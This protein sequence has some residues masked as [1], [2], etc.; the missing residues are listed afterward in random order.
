VRV[1]RQYASG[2]PGARAGAPRREDE[3]PVKFVITALQLLLPLIYLGAGAV[4]LRYYVT[5]ARPLRRL[6][7]LA[8]LT[9]L[10]THFVFLLAQGAA[11]GWIPLISP[12][13]AMSMTAAAILGVYLVIEWRS[14]N[15][16]MGVFL[17]APALLF[18]VLSTFLT[19]E[20]TEVPKI[21]LSVRLP[22]HALPAVL[23]YA[24]LAIG[25]VFSMLMLVLR[26]QIKR[27]RIGRI[28]RRLPSLRVLDT[29]SFHATLAGFAL[30]SLSVVT[31]SM[32]AAHEWNTLL[33]A[34]PKLMGILVVWAMYAIGV[35]MRWLPG[36]SR[37][38]RTLWLLV[39]FGALTFTFSLLDLIVESRHSW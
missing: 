30:L 17:I 31:G 5:R 25:A 14:N 37:R 34:D 28:Y 19:G 22:I 32:W 39:C 1:R 7:R 3:S 11:H 15:R 10:G 24:G 35:T 18:Q 2:A 9:T 8:L 29:M 23:G 26:R 27:R 38:T 20:L 4:Y 21:L 33:P 16:V 36:V 12:G 13:H 6:C